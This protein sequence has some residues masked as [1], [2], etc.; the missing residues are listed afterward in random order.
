MLP[1]LLVFLHAT[2]DMFG[3]FLTPLLPRLQTAFNVDYARVSMLIAIYSMS[4][5]LF[6]P[7][8][9]LIADRFDKRW[10]AALGPL[11]VAVGVGLV[12]F[13]PNIYLF[14][15]VLAF[16]GLGSALFHSS[17]AALVGQYAPENKKGLWISIFGSGGHLGFS[18]A[19]AVSV[20]IAKNYGLPAIAWVVPLALIPA[21]LFLK[22][23][24]VVKLP[25]K[26]SNFQDLI[27]VFKGEV[28]K[29]WAL[30]TLRIIVFSSLTTTIPYWFNRRGISDERMALALTVSSVSGILGTLLG[31]ILSDK[32]GRKIILTSSLTAAI[33][34]FALLVTIPPESWLYIPLLSIAGIV[35]AASIPV[36]VVMA[37]SYEPKQIATVSGLLMGFT[38][39]FSG[40]LYGGVGP[41]VEK[42][43]ILV[44]LRI[45]GLLLIPALLI[46]LSLKQ[47]PSTKQIS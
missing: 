3:S 21:I 33:P 34:L 11:F 4:S 28:A 19:P 36:T 23:A 44:V 32:L 29:L 47:G 16:A 46:A 9:G 24:P 17:A 40:L 22:F 30:A 31:G 14:A 10:L 5:S 35:S 7:V 15:F 25:G 13:Y 27:R 37:Q 38:W 43:G 41:M 1:I 45:I 18:L 8:A 6:Q 12:G 39:G 20:G 2:N 42:F 26:H